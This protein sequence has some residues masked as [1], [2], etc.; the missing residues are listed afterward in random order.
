MK[1]TVDRL[2]RLQQDL[3][4]IREARARSEGA[5]EQSMKKLKEDFG[6]SSLK[7]AEKKLTALTAKAQEED[8]KLEEMV[9]KFE[10]EY[11]NELS[12]V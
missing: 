10:E 2:L 7:E 4:D 5:L 6:C 12:R 9:R 1:K 11:A 8:A 3:R